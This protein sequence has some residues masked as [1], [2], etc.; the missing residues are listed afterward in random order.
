[1]LIMKFFKVKFA[2]FGILAFIAA[3]VFLTSC[4][5]ETIEQ[6]L[7]TDYEKAA[8]VLDAYVVE[9]EE[10][11]F[12]LIETD[13]YKLSIAPQVFSQLVES[14]NELNSLIQ[15]GEVD[16]TTINKAYDLET[17]EEVTISDRGC[18]ENKIVNTWWGKKYYVSKHVMS[19]ISAGGCYAVSGIGGLVCGVLVELS[20]EYYCTCGYIA[21]MT[22]NNKV[23]WAKC[24]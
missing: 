11:V 8:E 12:T 24:Q 22:W 18:N 23:I 13:P 5:Q 3:S 15:R 21:Y 19:L 9:Q 7:I 10:G 20:N 1:M 14:L 2:A 17:M 16:A 6:P 4:E